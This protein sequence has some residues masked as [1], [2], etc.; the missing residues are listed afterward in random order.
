MDGRHLRVNIALTA[1][2]RS[3]LCCVCCGKNGHEAKTCRIPWEKIKDKQKQME[4]RGKVPKPAQSVIV[5]CN[6]A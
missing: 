6:M 4:G 1:H 5:H 2:E 3:D